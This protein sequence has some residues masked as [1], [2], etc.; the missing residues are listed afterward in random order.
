MPSHYHIYFK[1]TYRNGSVAEHTRYID[2]EKPIEYATDIEIV[3]K[4]CAELV[5]AETAMLIHWNAL[6]GHIRPSSIK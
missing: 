5:D 1:A 6:K 2:M 3:E 4:K